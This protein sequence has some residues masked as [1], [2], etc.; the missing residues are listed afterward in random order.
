MLWNLCVAVGALC[1]LAVSTV[2]IGFY[3]TGLTSPYLKNF[4]KVS[5]T[6]GSRGLLE[7]FST[8]LCARLRHP[9]LMFLVGFATGVVEAACMVT[10]SKCGKQIVTPG[11]LINTFGGLLA[12]VYLRAGTPP[13]TPKTPAQAM[14][15][16]L[17]TV[18]PGSCTRG[19]A[20]PGGPSRPALPAEFAT[21]G[22]LPSQYVEPASTGVARACANVHQRLDEMYQVAASHLAEAHATHHVSDTPATPTSTDEAAI[23]AEAD[24]EAH[25]E[26]ATEVV[27]EPT[28]EPAAI[29]AVGG[30]VH[31]W[32]GAGSKSPKDLDFILEQALQDA[33]QTSQGAA[34]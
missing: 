2:V 11:Q 17:Q 23:E 6:P 29:E 27:V 22:S 5:P 26:A 7:Q 25:T 21:L 19:P 20:A 32:G 10:N 1:T 8:S 12:A 9:F 3:V 13:A 31:G 15:D 14:T 30:I 4:A 18:L 33:E 28:G 34:D 24:T 16:F